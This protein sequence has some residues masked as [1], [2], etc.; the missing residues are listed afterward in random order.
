MKIRIFYEETKYRFRNWKSAVL[1]LRTLIKSEGKLVG[2]INIIITSDR[3][4]RPLNLEFLNHNYNTDVIAF[5]DNKGRILNGEI[6]ISKDTVKRNA[7]NY[8]VSLE[9]EILRVIIHG[10]LHL[11]G[12]RDKNY[13]EKEYM[14]KLEDKWLNIYYKEKHGV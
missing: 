12:Y 2:E 3:I 7:F 4:L 13:K 5:G 14:H 9:S 6:Y 11:A 8:N 1:L 10:I